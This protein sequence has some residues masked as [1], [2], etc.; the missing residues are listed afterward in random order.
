MEHGSDGECEV[1]GEPYDDPLGLK[2]DG[3]V[4]PSCDGGDLS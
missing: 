2:A 3:G 4:C 1:C